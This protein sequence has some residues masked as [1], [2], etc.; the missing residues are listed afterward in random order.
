MSASPLVT[1]LEAFADDENRKNY[2]CEARRGGGDD[3]N[4]PSGGASSLSSSTCSLD[5]LERVRARL[6]TDFDSSL[7]RSRISLALYGRDTCTR[8]AAVYEALRPHTAAANVSNM[9]LCGDM[10]QLLRFGELTCARCNATVYNA[11]N[12][13]AGEACSRA[14]HSVAELGNV[15]RSRC[16]CIVV[17]MRAV[18]GVCV[19]ATNKS[20]AV[21]DIY[22]RFTQN[23]AQ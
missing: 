9:I 14:T 4:D 16:C 23:K 12:I 19:D 11:H 1:R 22:T 3:D 15:A 6:T 2:C 8:H 13:F 21:R 17:Q 20:R 5:P 10:Q 18:C 7:Q